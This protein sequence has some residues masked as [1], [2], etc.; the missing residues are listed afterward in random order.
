[1]WNKYFERWEIYISHEVGT[2]VYEDM[3]LP[4]NSFGHFERN[5]IGFFAKII[6][7]LLEIGAKV[8]LGFMSSCQK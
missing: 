8:L 7:G 5:V 1:M 6:F 4:R 3:F 2:L